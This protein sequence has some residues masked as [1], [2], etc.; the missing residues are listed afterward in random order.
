MKETLHGSNWPPGSSFK[1]PSPSSF[2]RCLRSFAHY[3][4]DAQKGASAQTRSSEKRV[5]ACVSAVWRHVPHN[6][7]IWV[8]DGKKKKRKTQEFRLVNVLMLSKWGEP[9]GL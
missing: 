5:R 1:Q 4:S 2:T 9:G 8:V 7:R 3:T 6:V